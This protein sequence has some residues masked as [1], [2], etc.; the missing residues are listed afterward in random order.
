MTSR[1]YFGKMNSILGSVVPL[2]M[3]TAL[4][5][6]NSSMYAFIKCQG[7]L[8]RYWNGLMGLWAKCW[9]GDWTKHMAT[10][11]WPTPCKW[12]IPENDFQKCLFQV[13][14]ALRSWLEEAWGI[15]VKTVIFFIVEVGRTKKVPALLHKMNFTV[16]TLHSS[17]GRWIVCELQGWKKYQ[18]FLTK[19]ISQ[20]WYSSPCG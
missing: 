4:H 9:M 15:P 1:C 2:A 14:S 7:S 19:S 10:A 8:E 6:L 18:L 12:G 5:C 11:T 16:R 13:A 20:G 17:P 3:F